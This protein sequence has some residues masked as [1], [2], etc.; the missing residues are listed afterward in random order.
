MA[1][2]DPA[3]MPP[4]LQP[5]HHPPLSSLG[6]SLQPGQSGALTPSGPATGSPRNVSIEKMAQ[7]WVVS[8]LPPLDPETPVATYSVQYKEGSGEWTMLD[9]ISKDTAYLSEFIKI[10]L[11]FCL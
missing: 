1:D 2:P 4:L 7:G 5:G 8:W 11:I 9:A 3:L 6:Q 10:K